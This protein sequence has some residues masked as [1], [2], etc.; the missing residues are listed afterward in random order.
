MSG[1]VAMWLQHKQAQDIVD[2]KA[3]GHDAA[4]RAMVAT[5]QGVPDQQNPKFL[6]S[7]ALMGAGKKNWPDTPGGVL[8]LAY[9]RY[10][11]WWQQQRGWQTYESQSCRSRLHA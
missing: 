9:M 1:I 7:V 2:P 11:Q 6:E 10:E 8:V 4:L 5:A 3:L